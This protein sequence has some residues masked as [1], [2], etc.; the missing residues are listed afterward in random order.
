MPAGKGL[1]DLGF[2][3]ITLGAWCYTFS[4]TI[5]TALLPQMQGDLSVGLDQVTWVVT[6]GGGRGGNR[7][8]LPPPGSRRASG[9]R[10]CSWAP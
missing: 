4:T 10:T 9:P 2:W 3:S 1:S 7:E 5:G 6:A 8:S